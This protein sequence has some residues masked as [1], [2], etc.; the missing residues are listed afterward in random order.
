MTE[1]TQPPYSGW[2]IVELMGHRQSAGL[3]SE[4]M[5]A[6]AAML[7]IDTPGADGEMVATQFYS[8]R[9][10]YA[11]TPCAES[12]A[13]AML[14]SQSYNLPPAVQ[15]VLPTEPTPALPAPDSDHFGD[16]VGSFDDGDEW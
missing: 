14:A 13:R 4:V 3:I 6:G 12:V 15:L 2:A 10:I 7:R 11:L 5:M 1:A 16:D 9:A 8:N